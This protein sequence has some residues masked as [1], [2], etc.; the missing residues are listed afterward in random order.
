VVFP[1]CRKT[2]DR[3]RLPSTIHDESDYRL[4]QRRFYTV[5]VFSE[6]KFQEILDDIP[7]DALSGE[8][9]G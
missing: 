7:G 2:L 5:K 1:W 4:W 3:P 8:F 6:R 9:S